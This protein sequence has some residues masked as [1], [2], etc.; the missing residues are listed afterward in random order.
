LLLLCYAELVKLTGQTPRLLH[1][2]DTSHY[3]SASRCDVGHVPVMYGDATL[4]LGRLLSFLSSLGLTSFSQR[5]RP[6][7][8][9]LHHP[10]H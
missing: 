8:T 5:W 2:V 10:P 7:S 1:P 3:G 9:A 4:F 6:G